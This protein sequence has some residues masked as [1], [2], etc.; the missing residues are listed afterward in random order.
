MTTASDATGHERVTGTVSIGAY[1]YNSE[2]SSIA[3][4]PNGMAIGKWATHSLK[5]IHQAIKNLTFSLRVTN[6]QG[7]LALRS[8]RIPAQYWRH[9]SKDV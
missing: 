8:V 4:G 6:T 9:A 3:I 7:K 5:F 1:E 2:Q